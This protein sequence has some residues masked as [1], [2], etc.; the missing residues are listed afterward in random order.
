MILTDPVT[1]KGTVKIRMP[2]SNQKFL[3]L[4]SQISQSLILDA[5]MGGLFTVKAKIGAIGSTV[6]TDIPLLTPP[7]V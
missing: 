1:A 2:K 4:G 3:T 5:E 6:I 7:E